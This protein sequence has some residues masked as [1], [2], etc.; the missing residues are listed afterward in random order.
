MFEAT[1]HIG[2][3]VKVFVSLKALSFVRVQC[4]K[5]ACSVVT[6]SRRSWTEAQTEQKPH[7]VAI[8]VCIL[9][10][11]WSLV[12]LFI[13][14]SV[15]LV[16]CTQLT[17]YKESHGH[18]GFQITIFTKYLKHLRPTYIYTLLLWIHGVLVASETEGKATRVLTKYLK[19]QWLIPIYYI[20]RRE[21]ERWGCLNG[22]DK[23]IIQRINS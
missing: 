23:L 6:A 21:E 11:R 1:E 4:Q 7:K 13:K 22:F 10:A 14:K 17:Q 5:A 3:S 2:Q 18:A 9:N 12:S 15:S 19:G 16:F 20:C 8:N